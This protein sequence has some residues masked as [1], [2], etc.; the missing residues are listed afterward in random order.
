MEP[1][2]FTGF[3]M[4]VQYR[5]PRTGSTTRP[6]GCF[7]PPGMTAV[8]SDPSGLAERT[9]PALASRKKIRPETRRLLDSLPI[10]RLSTVDILHFSCSVWIVGIRVRLLRGGLGV[11][12]GL[13][14][15]AYSTD[16]PSGCRPL[17]AHPP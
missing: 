3:P 17:E 7:S 2:F 16:P 9:R 6:S 5:C 8:K 15:P 13:R 14:S 11:P 12:S 1:S 10:V 4:L